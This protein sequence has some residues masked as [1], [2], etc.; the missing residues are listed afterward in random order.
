MNIIEKGISCSKC[1][2]KLGMI[3]EVI[4]G[5]NHTMSQ[6]L[7]CMSCLPKM[8]LEAEQRHYKPEKIKKLRDWMVSK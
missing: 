3:S 6:S 2:V 7:T 4:N 5:T 1:G 8:L